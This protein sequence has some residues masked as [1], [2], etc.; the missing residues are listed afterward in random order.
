M[1]TRKF[2][3]RSTAFN[4]I[5]I[6]S[7][8]CTKLNEKD[9]LV[10][11]MLVLLKKQR[12]AVCL[13]QQ[14]TPE[15]QAANCQCIFCSPEAQ[16]EHLEEMR[17]ELAEKEAAAAAREKAREQTRYAHWMLAYAGIRYGRRKSALIRGL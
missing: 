14:G 16:R 4:K 11:L 1:A 3:G 10:E 6:G 9:E 8:N 12:A 15:D 5:S 2:S 13:R 7:D 17:A